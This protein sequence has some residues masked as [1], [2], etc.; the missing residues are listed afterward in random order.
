VRSS[1]I[2]K[3]FFLIKILPEKKCTGLSDKRHLLKCVFGGRRCQFLDDAISQYVDVLNLIQ[4]SLFVHRYIA[5]GQILHHTKVQN[6]STN[7]QCLESKFFESD[8]VW[9]ILKATFFVCYASK[10]SL[11]FFDI[12]NIN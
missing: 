8:F 2:L 1:F 12:Y 11:Y 3:F 7:F 10:E 6:F 5:F 4:E 9:F